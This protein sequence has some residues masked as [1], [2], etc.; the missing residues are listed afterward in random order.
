MNKVKNYFMLWLI[1]LLTVLIMLGC[2]EREGLTSPPITTTPTVSST[3]P[4][5]SAVAVPINQQITATFSEEMNSSTI[6]TA[7]FTLMQGTSFVSGTVSYTGTTAAF[8]PSSNLS[9]NTSYTAT[10]T[11]MAKNLAGNTLAN[12]FTW[13][14]TTGSAAAITPPTVSSTDPVNAATGV[15]INQKVAATFSVAM[16]ATTITAS[17]FTLL[18]GATPV[19]GLV[20]YSGTTTIFAPASNLSPNTVYTATITTGAKDLAGNA[21]KNNYE[22]SFTTGTTAII[23]PPTV[24]FTA[25]ASSE[26]D[27]SLNQ[28]VAVT[29]SRTMD[30]ATI[31]ASTFTLQQGTT[32]ISGSVS[33]S[34]KTAIFTPA[35]NLSPNTVYTATI[36]TGAK[37]LAG[38]TLERNYIFSFTTGIDVVVTS[39]IV[40]STDPANTEIGVPFNQKIAAI[41]SKTMDA[42]T[43]TTATFILMQGTTSVSGFVSY[44]GTT[45]T[46]EP[47]SN[48]LPNST[49]R[50]V[51]TTGAADL[52]GNA[53][54]NNYEW[55]FTTGTVPV[56]TAPTIIFTNPDDTEICVPLNEQITATFSEPM[57]AS[58]I[59]TAVFTLMRDDILIAGTVSYEDSTATYNPTNNLSPNTTYTATITT[60]ASDLTGTRLEENY[61]WSFTTVV[62]YTVTLSSNP[63]EGGTTNGSGTFNSCDLITVTA[64]PNDGY[65]FVNWTE[66][67]IEVSSNAIYEFTLEENT[68]LVANFSELLVQYSVTLSSNPAEGGT[69]NGSGTFDEGSLVTV[70]ATPNDGYQ[71]V[72]WTENGIEESS[73]ANYEFTI[74]EDRDLVANFE[75]EAPS[76]PPPVVLGAAGDFAIL[77]GSGVS[78]IGLTIIYGD[79]GSFPTATIDGFP[80]GVVNGTLYMTADPLVGAAKDDLTAAYNDAQSRSLDAISL[81]GQLG[82]L[83]LAPGLYVNSTTSGIS[84]TGPNGILTLDA[85]GN[86]N[87]VWIFKVGSTFITDAGTSIVLAGGAKWEN[88]FWSVGT[89]A[90]LGTNSVF[91]GNI[92][93]DQSITLTTGAVLNGRAL[94]RIAAITLESNIV[95]KR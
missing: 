4:A 31:T 60:E 49:Y 80:P 25:P 7:T 38:N 45:A 51:I 41:F 23:T 15:P 65:E 73:N 20:S 9:P 3:N 75:V 63:S 19:S 85:G 48:L 95:D 68:T 67:G 93:A 78:N 22:W 82:G 84:G 8:A 6:T 24:S 61:V 76:G 43:I 55:S 74:I 91:Y 40:S 71:F 59:T 30:A 92:L 89:S 21:L 33:Y 50:V 86:E 69:T 58:T 27:V 87:A 37:D 57:N 90:T 88:I 18:R 26:A 12:N 1:P 54:E 28:K 81:P 62:P 13:T 64:T 32:P 17:T 36:T 11:T 39:P 44:S 29:F 52:A 2:E 10:I 14:F 46:F 72:N 16:D 35:S 42:T 56:I 66:N 83:S 70:T 79:V 77:A 5:N 47:A 53:L 34:G 94:T